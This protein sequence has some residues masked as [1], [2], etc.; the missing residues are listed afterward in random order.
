MGVL[1]R[2]ISLGAV[3]LFFHDYCI[4]NVVGHPHLMI[5]LMA[6]LARLSTADLLTFK[7]KSYRLQNTKTLLLLF[8][9][10]NFFFGITVLST[11]VRHLT[12]MYFSKEVARV[13][14]DSFFFK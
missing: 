3:F 11:E 14:M 4:Y 2:E 6:K 7:R 13:T 5:W 1:K 10:F 8:F 12:V 9:F